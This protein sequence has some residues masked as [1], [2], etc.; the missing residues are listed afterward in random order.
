M[1]EFKLGSTSL[2]KKTCKALKGVLNSFKYTRNTLLFMAAASVP[3]DAGN[4]EMLEFSSLKPSTFVA[5]PKKLTIKVRESSSPL[6]QKLKKPITFTRVVAKGEI[7]NGSINLK[8]G[9]EQG[10]FKKKSITDDY[11]LRLGLVLEGKNK[12]PKYLPKFMLPSWI[13]RLFSLAPKDKGVDK[14]YFLKVVNNASDVGK[15]REHPLNKLIF[16]EGAVQAKTGPFTIDKTFDSPKTVYGIW[17]SANGEGTQSQF[18]TS[19]DS[20]EF[21]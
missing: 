20:I 7:T 4:W 18:D 1:I 10:I 2:G 21:Y 11:A 16:E 13:K 19:I 15:K 3:L 12:K 17:L 14:I 9:Q 6:I 5:T 8:D